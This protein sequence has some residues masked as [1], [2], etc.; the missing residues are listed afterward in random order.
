MH[1]ISYCSFIGFADFTKKLGLPDMSS[2]GPL[3]KFQMKDITV[4]KAFDIMSEFGMHEL[5]AKFEKILRL[6]K[7]SI[8]LNYSTD[9]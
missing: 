6:L 7:V 3:F 1:Y 4:K 9:S 5:R 2:L 8:I